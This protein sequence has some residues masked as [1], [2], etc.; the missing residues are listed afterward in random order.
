MKYKQIL[1]ILLLLCLSI[2][3]YIFIKQTSKTSIKVDLNSTIETIDI[4]KIIIPKKSMEFTI[5]KNRD[6]NISFIG[7][8]S[9]SQTP[10]EIAKLLYRDKFQHQIKIDTKREDSNITIPL[11]EK[12]I[13]RFTDSY[14]QWS[15]VYKNKKLLINGK[16]T[17]IEDKNSVERVLNLSTLNSFSNIELIKIDKPLDIISN[18]KSVVEEEE[19]EMIKE[20]TPSEDEI[21]DILL[22]LKSLAVEEPKKEKKVIRKKRVIVKKKKHIVTV[23]KRVKN[24]KVVT[25]KIIKKKIVKK[26]RVKKEI[27]KIKEVE[28]IEIKDKIIEDKAIEKPKKNIDI[29]SL[30]FVKP[31]DVEYVEHLKTKKPLVK[32]ETIY[33]KSDE[34]RV[35]KEIPWAKLHN[36][37]EKV[38][39]VYTY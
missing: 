23:K 33:I 36:V 25:K 31:I 9:T 20:E 1:I 29:M 3:S 19:E 32:K 28:H 11:I 12:V 38:N 7:I 16:T 22:N 34:N 39:G 37:N 8:F 13:N 6:G 14:M 30:P 21:E 17:N 27:K 26:K 10:I 2:V 5:S 4:P 35:D 24:K 15:I 18:L